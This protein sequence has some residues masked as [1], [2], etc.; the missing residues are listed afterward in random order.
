M[1]LS[2]GNDAS[3]SDPAPAAQPG[4]SGKMQRIAE[5][6][7]ALVDDLKQWVDLRVEL[8][9]IEAEERIEAK[10]NDVALGVILG[11]LGA[12][13]GFF[14][15]IT[16]ALGLGA[17]LGHPGWGFL[18][19]TLFLALLAVVIRAARPQLVD[20]DLRATTDAGPAAASSPRST[21]ASD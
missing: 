3:V 5:H 9:R 13:A 2:A 14:G 1:E 10:A 6:S 11:V 12:L 18:I 16:V 19:V 8:A 15:L 7:Q 21:G 17:L 4:P 20:I